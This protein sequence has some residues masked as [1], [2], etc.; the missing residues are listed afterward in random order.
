MSDKAEIDEIKYRAETAIEDGHE[1]VGFN[2]KVVRDLIAAL[3]AA[4][5]RPSR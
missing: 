5:A 4:T 3:D 1:Y 2:P